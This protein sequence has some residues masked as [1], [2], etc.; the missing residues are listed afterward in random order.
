MTLVGHSGLR[1]FS[2]ST[3]TPLVT[4]SSYS[5]CYC[6]RLPTGRLPA[7]LLRSLSTWARHSLTGLSSSS[8]V[9][10][11][12]GCARGTSVA[13]N[14]GGVVRDAGRAGVGS[15]ES[16][17]LTNRPHLSIHNPRLC[18]FDCRRAVAP[19]VTSHRPHAAAPISLHGSVCRFGSVVVAM[20]LSQGLEVLRWHPWLL[21]MSA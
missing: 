10:P 4:S 19:P 3:C 18:L 9:M 1:L 11:L 2:A 7:A 6:S 20:T 15:S 5:S 21:M 14:D 8:I 17:G 13:A 12:C 16:G